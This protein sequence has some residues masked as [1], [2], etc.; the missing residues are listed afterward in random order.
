MNDKIVSAASVLIRQGWI[1]APSTS[2]SRERA[3]EASLKL[4]C[5]KDELFIQWLSSFEVVENKEQTSCFFMANTFL[6]VN[7][8]EWDLVKNLDIESAN[9]R[10]DFLA[11]SEEFWKDK[12]PIMLDL[13]EGDYRSVVATIR[14]EML[15]DFL[16]IRSPEYRGEKILAKDFSSLLSNLAKIIR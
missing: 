9:D 13:S 5:A 14:N 16:D 6:E 4:G 3:L 2:D 11:D 7:G 8:F 12:L 10:P 1:L 15:V